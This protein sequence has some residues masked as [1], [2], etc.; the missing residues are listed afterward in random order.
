MK[1]IQE[2][3]STLDKL[4]INKD[5]EQL[6]AFSGGPDSVFLLLTL[7]EYGCTNITLLYV[8][9]HDS[10]YIDQE[11]EIVNHYANHK[12]VK[13]VTYDLKKPLTRNFE[14][15]ARKI[16]YNFF[17][18]Y[19]YKH[20]LS[21]IFI[22]HQKN[23]L[24]E[25]YILQKERNNLV[26]YYG[27]PLKSKLENIELYRPL[28]DVTKEEE[29]EYLNITN[30]IFYDDITNSNLKRRRNYLRHKIIKLEDFD[31]YQEKIRK[32]NEKLE[33]EKQ[34]IYKLIN[35]KTDLKKFLSLPLETKKR[36]IYF[37]LETFLEESNSH[38]LSLINPILEYAKSNK[39]SKEKL[40]YSLAI[41]K[42][43]S[44]FYIGKNI[45]EVDYIHPLKL[46]KL[47]SF[48]EVSIDLRDL[49]KFNFPH[50]KK[51]YV[52]NVRENDVFS[53]N[54]GHKSVN[55]FLKKNKVP[56][57]LRKVYPVIVNEKDEV[58]FAP[59]Y[60]NLIKENYPVVIR[61]YLY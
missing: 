38:I 37:Y 58:I 17:K 47:N 50:F 28:L 3:F 13:L 35:V 12:F 55:N 4:N 18:E 40:A 11:V 7:L 21:H 36:Y 54:V 14:A 16:R 1:K 30:N 22:A 49:S 23:D 41:Y 39:T 56:A 32:D 46:N 60:E 51:L 26:T 45:K 48:K 52:R 19:A 6:L 2:I 33:E 42:S 10:I 9:Y 57:Y 8:N 31:T 34:V 25:T 59:F 44:F 5:E 15:E 20:S 29:I 24:I 53:T 43:N 61:N 27:L